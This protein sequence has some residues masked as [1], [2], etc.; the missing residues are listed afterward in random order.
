MNQK[1]KSFFI[2]AVIFLI[3]TGYIYS[4]MKIGVALP[5]M[6]SSQ[7]EDDKILAQQ[8]LT[9]INKALQE[10]NNANPANKI[11][12]ITE[13]TKRDQAEVLRIFDKLGSDDKVIAIL[14]PVFSSE[15][16]NNAGA[17]LFHK[18]PIITPTST[19]SFLAEKN[20][21]LFQLN[22]TYDIR[23]RIMADFAC[24]ELRMKNFVIFSEEAYGN[25]FAQ[26][27]TDQVIKDSGNIIAIKYYS[28]DK[29]ELTEELEELRSK[30]FEKDKF[31]DFGSLS[32]DQ[33][34]KLSKMKFRF[35]NTDS[36]VSQRLIVSIYKIFGKNADRI[37]D[38]AGLTS[39][40]IRA[41]DFSKKY[42]PG[43]V[44]AV[45]I[46]VSN[47]YEITKVL[48]QFYAA[49]INLPVLG[50]SDWNNSVVLDE[51][52]AYI[53]KLYFD[54]DFHI[55]DKSAEDYSKSDPELKNYYF[56]YDAMKLILSKIAEGNNTRETLNTS[57]EKVSGYKAVHCN[58]TIRER[59][60]HQMSIMTY[61][62]GNI[63]KL[64]DF[65][66]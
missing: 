60:N 19:Q 38:S 15:L 39:M 8:M 23:G 17:A 11:E 27:F 30:I 33:L 49:G 55:T 6:K 28:K 58:F 62:N 5:M 36:L 40:V 46:P 2:L 14:G 53:D 18:I 29:T 3:N 66:Y 56:G 54:S 48:P 44:D 43:Y 4:Q 35:S 41:D 37:I 42:I 9:G 61:R 64:K 7:N 31:I 21:Y 32:K 52:A 20:P 13:D 16:V 24:E 59:T 25:N 12:I 50:S 57:L 34:D 51:N 10:F 63:E 47:A 45:Y 1:V 65:V 26:S 22:P